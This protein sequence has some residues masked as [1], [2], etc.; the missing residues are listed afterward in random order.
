MYWFTFVPISFDQYFQPEE[1][2]EDLLTV[3]TESIELLSIDPC[4][5]SEECD[6]ETEH[7]S[8]NR[9]CPIS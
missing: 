2:E 4:S 5:H 7:S 6:S 8:R 3:N 1:W 9:E